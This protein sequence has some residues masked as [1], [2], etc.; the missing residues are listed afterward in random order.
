MT[1]SVKHQN[2]TKTKEKT[3]KRQ[4]KVEKQ[5]DQ[6]NQDYEEFLRDLEEDKEMRSQV[7][8]F[9][10]EMIVSEDSKQDEG[11]NDNGIVNDK[12]GNNDSDSDLDENFPD[13][14]P[15]ELL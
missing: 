9:R 6:R 10:K 2:K 8:M 12:D 13:I 15:D 3:N 4:K 1:K 7:N 5:Q 14:A 11:E